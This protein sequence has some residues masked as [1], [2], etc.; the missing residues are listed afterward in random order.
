MLPIRF[1]LNGN[2]VASSRFQTVLN[3]TKFRVAKS[4]VPIGEPNVYAY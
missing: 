2:F 1:F 3:K 4:G